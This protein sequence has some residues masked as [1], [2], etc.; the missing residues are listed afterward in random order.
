MED[1]LFFRGVFQTIQETTGGQGTS[2]LS[3]FSL[4]AL[5]KAAHFALMCSL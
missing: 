5:V 3:L 2:L 4:D 1:A